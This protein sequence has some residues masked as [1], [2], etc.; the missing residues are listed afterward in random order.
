MAVG[1]TE[2]ATAGQAG[3]RCLTR[4]D[5][6]PLVPVVRILGCSTPACARLPVECLIL[7]PHYWPAAAARMFIPA[8][9]VFGEGIA[10]EA[11]CQRLQAAAASPEPGIQPRCHVL[12]ERGGVGMVPRLLRG[13]HDSCLC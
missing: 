4:T 10:P 2:Q 7:S 3:W 8:A 11:A 9:E 5:G 1:G 13:M 12:G 6:M